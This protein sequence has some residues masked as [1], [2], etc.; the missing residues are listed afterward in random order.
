MERSPL[1]VVVVGLSLLVLT[2]GPLFL[3]ARRVLQGAGTWEDPVVRSPLVATALVAAGLVAL[4]RHRVSGRRLS[5]PSLPAA[6][7]IAAY[8]ALAVLSTYWS[9]APDLTLWRAVVYL[10]LPFLAWVIADLDDGRW[11]TMMAA[12]LAVAVFASLVMVVVSPSIGLDRNDD[13]RGIYTNRNSLAPLAV[14]G[15]IVGVGT[16]LRST[17]RRHHLG[18]V[19]VVGSLVVLAGT[20]SRT[21]WLGM[22]VAIGVGSL[23]VVSRRVH[24][25]HGPGRAAL[26]GGGVGA[27]GLVTVGLAI[28]RLW[29][30]STFE[31]RRTIW[32]L[33]WDRIVDRPVHGH[34]FF[35]V[36][37]VPAFTSDHLLLERGSA[38]DSALEVWLGLG[39]LG[40][41]PFAAIVGLALYGV[42]REAWSRPSPEAWVWLVTILFLLIENITESFVLWFSYNWVLIMAAALRS[43]MTGARMVSKQEDRS[44]IGSATPDPVA[45]A[46]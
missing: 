27:V 14:L 46:P 20:G 40:L 13:W 31:Q 43:G 4:D 42:V 28:S 23:V 7:V 34:G 33:V 39:L 26:V 17:R 19:L 1:R 32:S 29:S 37:D 6:A 2:N 24:D 38:H 30:E 12:I 16:A 21:A 8:S 35:A 41:I 45:A 10:G 9:L 18:W 11:L 36:W 3:I 44:T 22:L 5:R 25:R 15:V